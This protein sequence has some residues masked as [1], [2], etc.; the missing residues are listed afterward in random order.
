M[1]RHLAQVPLLTFALLVSPISGYSRD[2]SVAN[3][4]ALKLVVHG[5]DFGS[6]P[7]D[8]APDAAPVLDEVA[9]LVAADNRRVTIAEVR[10]GRVGSA[11]FKRALA[12]RRARSVK[13]Y[14][15]AHGIPPERIVVIDTQ[16]ASVPTSLDKTSTVEVA[17]D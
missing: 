1:R 14:L 5:V 13:Q 15:V 9:Q 10:L 7:T 16:S 4:T 6:R 12:R 11:A 8:I 3:A 17:V 2:A